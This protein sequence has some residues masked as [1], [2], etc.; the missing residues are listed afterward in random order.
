MAINVLFSLSSQRNHHFLALVRQLALIISYALE[1]K[2]AG[3]QGGHC[4]L[5]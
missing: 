4:E 1:A 2:A 3:P 5:N